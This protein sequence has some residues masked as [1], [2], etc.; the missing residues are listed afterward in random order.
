LNVQAAQEALP[1][2]VDIMAEELGWSKEEKAKQIKDCEHFLATQMG[3]MVN[4]QSRDKIPI[5][6]TQEE[7]SMYMKRFEIIDKDKKGFVSI[8]DI[9]RAMKV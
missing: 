6:L 3:L 4:R 7:V 9:K 5:N 8:N 1:G 2:I